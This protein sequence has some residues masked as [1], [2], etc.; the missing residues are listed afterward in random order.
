MRV[1]PTPTESGAPGLRDGPGELYL[2]FVG[3]GVDPE[4]DTPMELAFT[5]DGAKIVIAH[6]DSHNL[7]VFDAATRLVVGVIPVS[8]SPNSLAISSL[9]IYAVTANLFEDTASVV[10]LTTGNEVA[11]V[12]VGDQPGVVRIS[13]DGLTAVVGN[14][15]ES[16]LSVIDIATA[17][18]VQRLAGASFM[19][20]TSFGAWAITYRFTDYE[21]AADNATLVFPDTSGN[22]VMFF[23]IVTGDLTGVGS[24]PKPFAVDIAPDGVTAAIAHVYP[25]TKLSVVNVPSKTITKW[26]QVGGTATSPTAVAIN[27]TGTKAVM[28]LSNYVRVINLVTNGVSALLSTGAVGQ[29][30]TTADGQY[31]LVG[32]YLGSLVS[33]ST[34]TIVGNFL[35][36]TTPDALA[37][38]PTGPRAAT[39]HA[40]R[41]EVM[42]VMNTNGSAGYLEGVVATGPPPEGDKARNVALTPDAT[43]AV[44]INNHSLNATIIDVL[45]KSIVAVAPCGERPGAVAVT[46]AG[47]KAIVAN[48]DSTFATVIDLATATTNNVTISRRGS[49]VAISPDGTYAYIPVVA[50]GDGVWRININTLSVA[51]PKIATGNMGGIGFV[52]DLSSGIALSHSGATLVACGSFD[53]NLSIIN[54]TTWTE[55]LRLPVGTFPVRAV[56]SPDDTKIFVTNKTSNTVSVVNNA[57]GGSSV[58]ATIP[59]GAQPFDLALNPAG[60][61]LYVGNFQAKTVSVIALPA[62]TVTNTIPIPPTGGGGEP[63]G[64]QVS[65]DGAWLY[66]VANGADFHVID[67]AAAAIV[68]TLNTGL[69]PADFKFSDIRKCG[70]VPSP[71]GADGLSIMCHSVLGDLNCDG[72][73]DFGD[74]NPFVLALADPAAYAAAYPGC[75]LINRDINGSGS[76][77]FDDINP[78]VA[79]LTAP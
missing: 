45:S 51:G 11:V 69:A 12:P 47:T 33:Y 16:S 77:G 67:T 58:V 24:E 68:Q 41:K 34:E 72:A 74:I 32:N 48:L 50:D 19:Q 65:A 35:N 46:P 75:P 36:T 30:L 62:Y 1:S 60:T 3:V 52:F 10:D 26:I 59:V 40:L 17:T 27:S 71:Y 28:T 37:V 8:G 76:F 39:A 55:V 79:L 38:S 14:T 7:V 9:G 31:C 18:E 21:I 56:F 61:Q 54:T 25:E 44:V 53:N 42:E 6:R 64:L 15:L 20:I 49:Q 73:T 63:V 57:G 29:L 22:Q 66:V 13:P 70:Y 4:G 23:D 43:Q 2:S 5:P 78:F